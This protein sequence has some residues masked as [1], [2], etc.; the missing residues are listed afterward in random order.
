M[1]NKLLKKDLKFD[2]AKPLLLFALAVVFSMF[3]RGLAELGKSVA[4]FKVFNIV[5]QSIVYAL[6]GNVIAQSFIMPLVN[7]G[8][9]MYGDESYLTHT[10]PVKKSQIL[11]SK[12]LSA[13]IVMTCS[14]IVSLFC[15]FILFFSKSAFEMI[16]A[17]I[18]SIFGAY[19]AVGIIFLV[20]ALVVVEIIYYYMI[21]QSSIILANRKNEKRV[22]WTVIYIVIEEYIMVMIS[23]AVIAG[24]FAA[25]GELNSLSSATP[26]FSPELLLTALAVSLALYV[27]AIVILFFINKKLLEK[28]VNVD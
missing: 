8:K 26:A 23:L 18:A 6:I 25:F 14:I 27:G 15:F 11:F 5:I 20:V 13:S 12:S 2:F 1:F 3:S 4:F 24:V 9:T 16:K 28:G 19:S 7:F 21:I 10:L 17:F 22:M